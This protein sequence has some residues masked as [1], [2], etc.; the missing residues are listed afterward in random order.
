MT[1]AVL[2]GI[3]LY[4]NYC[5]PPND[6]TLRGCVDD[7]N[8][9]RLWF[10]HQLN[11]DPSDYLL[12]Q[13]SRA[14]AKTEKAAVLDMVVSQEGPGKQLIWSHSSHGSNNQDPSQRD[15][16][17]E[18][19]CSYDIR[20]VNG[21]WDE[22]TVITARWIGALLPKVRPID[23]LDII[24]D[25]CN[26]PEGS[27]LKDMGRRYEA[28]KFLPRSVVGARVC[29]DEGRLVNTPMPP[30][31]A[32]WSACQPN[33]TSADAFIGQQW[34]GAFTA[35]FLGAQKAGRG[36]QDIIF[37]A[38]K[39]LKENGYQQVC[40]LYAGQSMALKPFAS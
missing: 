26:A 5:H 3:N 4:K 14:S 24:L 18:L 6:D 28:A 13:D 1:Q 21:L 32:L 7:M 29:P 36:R 22:E 35:A 19:L 9:L 25:C 39:W 12:L 40:H 23:T 33:Q 15:G 34:Q 11:G 31:I 38:R 20:E 2:T 37:Y 16:L 27:Q 17:E 30:N 8:N 10:V